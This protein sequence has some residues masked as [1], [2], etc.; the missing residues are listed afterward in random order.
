M[1]VAIAFKQWLGCRN[2]LVFK[3]RLGLGVMVA[4]AFMLSGCF[5]YDVG[6]QFKHQNY[7]QIVQH[8]RVGERAA[9]LAEP[10]LDAWLQTLKARVRSLGGSLRQEGDSRFTLIVPFYS[11]AELAERFNHLFA[12]QAAGTGL[13]IP[14]LGQVQSHLEIHQ[15]N[16]LFAQRTRLVYDL[17]LGDLP[18]DKSPTGELD[19]LEL[20]FRIQ[21]PWGLSRIA[22]DSE[23]PQG[24]RWRLAPGQRHHIDVVFWVPS[25]LG[26]GGG[27]IIVWVIL[28][29]FLKYGLRRRRAVND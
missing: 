5:Q 26:I 16:R 11:G 10:T 6:I 23:Q 2:R 9:A 7:G 15:A 18:A 4:L 13:S 22:S 27:A 25:W 28:G 14:Q 17:D 21:T 19:W 8:I 12:P 20:E 1:K 3:S 29:Y 24:D